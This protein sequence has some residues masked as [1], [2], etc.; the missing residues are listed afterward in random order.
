[1]PA[2]FSITGRKK[3]FYIEMK[4]PFNQLQSSYQPGPRM[5][6][7]LGSLLYETEVQQ[8]TI[9]TTKRIKIFHFS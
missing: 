7:S 1:M 9:V 2:Y 8:I 4:M 5:H 6:S 3:K